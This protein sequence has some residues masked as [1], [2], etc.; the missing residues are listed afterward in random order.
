MA[1]SCISSSPVYERTPIM[2]VLT[3]RPFLTYHCAVVNETLF[4]V[5]MYRLCSLDCWIQV[6]YSNAVIYRRR[7]WLSSSILKRSMSIQILDVFTIRCRRSSILGWLWSKMRL[8]NN[9]ARILS[10]ILL[11]AGFR[12]ALI[13]KAKCTNWRK[14]KTWKNS[15]VNTVNLKY[16]VKQNTCCWRRQ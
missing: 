1:S 9:W 8:Q 6:I 15:C 4:D 10:T 7:R 2:T 11:R 16:S 3:P 12:S 5:L 14:M 13:G